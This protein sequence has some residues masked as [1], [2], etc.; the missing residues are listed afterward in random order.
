MRT[1]RFSLH[2]CTDWGCAVIGLLRQSLGQLTG[3]DTKIGHFAA[4]P[5]LAAGSATA[6]LRFFEKRSER[7]A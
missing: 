7:D 1:D 6:R 3:E 5:M 2:G 4:G